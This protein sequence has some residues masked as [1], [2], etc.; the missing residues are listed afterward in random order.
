[1]I[2]VGVGDGLGLEIAALAP[3]E[4]AIKGASTNSA[5]LSGLWVATAAF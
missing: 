3:A 2:G 4:M 1:M 5:S